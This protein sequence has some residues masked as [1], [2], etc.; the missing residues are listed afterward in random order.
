MLRRVALLSAVISFTAWPLTVSAGS[1]NQIG[2]INHIVVIYE[3]N[4]SFDNLYGG[5]EGVNGLTGAD[6]AQTTQ[7][8]QDGSVYSCLLQNDVNLV[9][10]PGPC[11]LANAPF[12][13]GTYIPAD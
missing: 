1:A 9:N 10:N 5:W 11:A 2:K 4:H 3:E 13:I 7:V 6:A 8:A 12:N